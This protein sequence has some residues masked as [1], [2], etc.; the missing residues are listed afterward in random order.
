MAST[1][2]K[3]AVLIGVD[4]Y[5]DPKRRLEGSVNDIEDIHAWLKQNHSPISISEFLSI[6]ENDPAQRFPSERR[7]AWPTYDN[8]TQEL[9]RITQVARPGDFVYFHFSGHGTLKPTKMGDYR[10][11][12][13]SDAALVLFGNED[14]DCYLRGI[15]LAR[16]FDDIVAKQ[17]RL[18]VVLDCCHAGSISRDPQSAYT[19]IRGVPWSTK[20]ASAGLESRP[21]LSRS[22]APTKNISRNAMTNQHWLLNP[23]GYTLIAACGPNEIAGECEGEDNKI[24]GALSYFLL[25]VLVSALKENI[26]ANSGSIYRQLRA[27]LHVPFPNQHPILLGNGLVTFIGAATTEGSRQPIC[28]IVKASAKDQIWL[29]VGHAH[30]VCLDD[31]YA[32]YHDG[33][34]MTEIQK[35]GEIVPKVRIKAIHALQSE[36]KIIQSPEGGAS[37]TAGLTAALVTHSR[38]KT[39]VKLV[40]SASKE[41]EEAL[42]KSIWLQA[43]HDKENLLDSPTFRVELDE[44]D[45]YAIR[46]GSGQL[47]CDL[48]SISVSDKH[49]IDKVIAVLEH[50]GKFASIENLENRADN[51]LTDADFSIELKPVG[52][53]GNNVASDQAEVKH[54]QQLSVT[55]TNNTFQSLNLTILNLQPLRGISRLYPSRDRGEWKVILP[56]GLAAGVELPGKV[57]FAVKMSIPDQIRAKGRSEVDDVLKFFVTTRPSSFAILELPELSGEDWSPSRGSS[58]TKLSDSLQHLNVG[59]LP[60]SMLRGEPNG[61]GERWACRNFVVRTS[62]A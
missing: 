12:E 40:E 35:N 6:N 55:F 26:R 60:S 1:P 8:I 56:E 22:L 16:L 4:F 28:S 45:N 59:R 14:S 20:I 13:G 36:T 18:T 11:D 30:G 47:L 33:S 29:N 17:L 61:S 41:L 5:V 50:L 48:P 9:G 7:S 19:R 58:S 43:V 27:R 57:S 38:P 23:E 51:A 25:R 49:A 32:L 44:M 52:N 15:E 42:G 10:D 31:E 53:T 34:R 2:S 62:L 46:N 39:C 37:I 3:W 24:H 21:A 54:K